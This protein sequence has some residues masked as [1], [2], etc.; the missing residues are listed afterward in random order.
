MS[1]MEEHK[2]WIRRILPWMRPE[3]MPGGWAE[4]GGM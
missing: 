1:V 4:W 2:R 3:S